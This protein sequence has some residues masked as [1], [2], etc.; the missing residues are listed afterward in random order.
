MTSTEDDQGMQRPQPDDTDRLLDVVREY[1]YHCGESPQD[2]AL[3][4]FDLARDMARGL[5]ARSTLLALAEDELALADHETE[6]ARTLAQA[7]ARQLQ[8][9]R[10][11][12]TEIASEYASRELAY[13]E[14]V[15]AMHYALIG[16]NGPALMTRHP[17][18]NEALGQI[19]K[20]SE[21]RWLEED[22][23]E[24]YEDFADACENA[25]KRLARPAPS[26]RWRTE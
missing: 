1:I 16:N 6:R 24:L 7:T 2:T 18:L 17:A 22:G 4:L 11:A 10:S 25:L 8:E 13:R 14:L 20:D 15:A 3:A 23:A 5:N 9:V 26:P 12:Y 21:Q 19:T